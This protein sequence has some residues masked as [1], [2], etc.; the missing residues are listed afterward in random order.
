MHGTN[1]RRRTR[2]ALTIAG[3][4]AAIALLGACGDPATK[5]RATSVRDALG[6]DENAIHEREAKVQEEVRTCMVDEGF[7]Y[8]PVDP[9]QMNVHMIGPGSDDNPHF[10]RTKGYGIT[11]TIGDRPAFDEGSSD[12]NQR[13]RAALSEA[14]QKAYDTALFGK[15]AGNDDGGGFTV[16][17]GPG[18][19]VAG[20][21]AAA[22][23]LDQA[24]CF[25]R[26]QQKVGDG[27][28]KLQR[29]G[30]E[31]QEMQERIAS[32]PR[33]VKADAAWSACMSKA[34]FEFGTPDDIPP[35]LF[36]KVRELQESQGGGQD[37]ESADTDAGPGGPAVGPPIADSPE[38]ALLQHEELAL[39]KA[40]D[41]CSEKTGRRATARK[42]R[43]EAERRFLEENP[44]LGNDTA[45]T[46]AGKG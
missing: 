36:G 23:D 14:D 32:D 9:S 13:I 35:Y 3:S 29:V 6:L 4:I 27:N 20:D 39:A 26:A 44:D 21:E 16:H 33:M 24:G 25:G 43:D 31:L 46:G 30:P 2:S 41:G 42:V 45:A 18:V 1:G 7:E 37:G 22:P 34:G 5:A 8:V 10:R 40:D 12:P 11:T 15:A 38:L 19:A 17:I 28:D